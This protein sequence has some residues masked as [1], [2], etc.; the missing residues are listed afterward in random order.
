VGDGAEDLAL[1]GVGLPQP[2][3]LR[4]QAAVG[5]GQ[6]LRACGDALLEPRVGAL[7]LFVQNDVVEGDG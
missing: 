2:G 7:Q 1:E 4:G 6:I 5:G 3:P